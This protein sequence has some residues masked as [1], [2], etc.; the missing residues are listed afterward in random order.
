MPYL[1]SIAPPPLVAMA[2]TASNEEVFMS[3]RLGLSGPQP[4]VHAP[5]ARGR[6]E[7][8]SGGPGV[9]GVCGHVDVAP[10]CAPGA[11]AKGVVES[12]NGRE[13]PPLPDPSPLPT[14]AGGVR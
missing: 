4:Q 5:S 10:G 11:N 6:G 2:G 13:L 3:P 12:T 7:G 14:L 8:I 1:E 9:T